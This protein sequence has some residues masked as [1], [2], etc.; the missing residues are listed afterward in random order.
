MIRLL[1]RSAQRRDAGVSAFRAIPL[2]GLL[3]GLLAGW[4]LAAPCQAADPATDLATRTLLL[5]AQAFGQT[6]VAVGT[7]GHILRSADGGKTWQLARVPTIATLTGVHFPDEQHGWAVGHDAIILH[8]DDGGL[9]WIKQYQ[10][11]D[12]QVSF[13]DVYFVDAQT[14]FVA[15]AYGQFLSTADGGRTWTQRPI[16][17]EDFF[18]NRLSRGLDGTLFLA[19]EH[20][21]LLRSND[22]GTTWVPIRTPYDGSFY[23][24][25]PLGPKTLLAHG[26]RGS[27][28][29]SEDN[30]DTWQAVSQDQHVLFATAVRMRNGII[31]AAGQ[32]RS[33]TVSRD[34]G[35]SFASWS[36]GLTTGVAELIE[37]ADGT[38]LAFGEQGI[39]RLPA[40]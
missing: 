16:I 10:G 39:T 30:G 32:A 4:F 29:R 19:G 11:P 35:R 14:G 1:E 21:T 33:F 22:R 31:V 7:G 2:H 25:L 6:V 26:L 12:L 15:G 36:P 37:A 8:S 13:L 27:L 24:V 9:T 20:G 18:L 34:D 40:P 38:L 17:T 28:F 23:G 5:D 3:L